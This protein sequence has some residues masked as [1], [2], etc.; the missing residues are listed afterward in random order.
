MASR[1]K[2]NRFITV[3]ALTTIFVLCIVSWFYM[4]LRQNNVYWLDSNELGFY[5][6]VGYDNSP[7]S[8]HE[9]LK[10][11]PRKTT[12]EL[13]EE[14]PPRKPDDVEEIWTKDS[15]AKTEGHL[16]WGWISCL[17][18]GASL[19]SLGVRLAFKPRLV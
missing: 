19:A 10:D 16:F 5:V 4:N 6:T 9:N 2:R 1:I 18:L 17:I 12:E 11:Y 15:I 13:L 14:F 7:Q 8:L 3:A